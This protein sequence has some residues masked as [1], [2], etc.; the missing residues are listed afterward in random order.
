MNGSSKPW[1]EW[2][3]IG[4]ELEL[5][6]GRKLLGGHSVQSKADSGQFQNIPANSGQNGMELTTTNPTNMGMQ[7]IF[8]YPGVIDMY[9]HNTLTWK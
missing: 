5:D 7:R 6:L 1:S 2:G 3:G 4:P 9:V 8:S